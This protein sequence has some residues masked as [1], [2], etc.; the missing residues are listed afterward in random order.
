MDMVGN[1]VFLKDSRQ[2][3][4]GVMYVLV[5]ATFR[6]KGVLMLGL[7][8]SFMACSTEKTDKST[9]EKLAQTRSEIVDALQQAKIDMAKLRIKEI[10]SNIAIYKMKTGKYP[11]SLEQAKKVFRNGRIPQDEW[12]NSFF[13]TLD[14]N[15]SKPV[16]ILSYGPDGKKD[17]GDDIS[18]CDI[19]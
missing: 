8:V 3:T 5:K 1:E 16:T 11:S 19:E 4:G 13:Y 6:L 7:G 12:N 10:E 17:G 9:T 14:S 15:C 2:R 18:N